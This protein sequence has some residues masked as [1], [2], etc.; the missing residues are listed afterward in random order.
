MAR[1][2]QLQAGVSCFPCEVFQGGAGGQQGDD[3][4]LGQGGCAGE[5]VLEFFG[6]AFHSQDDFILLYAGHGGDIDI[7]VDP[8]QV[9]EV[10]G[11]GTDSIF[12]VAEA[13]LSAFQETKP[14]CNFRLPES[15][16]QV[17]IQPGLQ[18]HQTP[19]SASRSM[20][21]ATGTGI[22]TASS[23]SYSRT[24]YPIRELTSIGSS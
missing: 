3:V 8:I 9:E 16:S 6:R 2:A 24:P 10:Q 18:L 22:L 23:D 20:F 13:D 5:G 11:T 21:M 14:A 1:S 7:G 17:E 19:S 12:H 15:T 4:L